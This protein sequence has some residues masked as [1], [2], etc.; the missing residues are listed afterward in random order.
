[1]SGGDAAIMDHEHGDW[2]L[3][4]FDYTGLWKP[5]L[6]DENDEYR[7]ASQFELELVGGEEVEIEDA[8]DNGLQ[9]LYESRKRTAHDPVPAAART[10]HRN[11][12][13]ISTHGHKLS[14]TIHSLTDS[15]MT[16][17]RKSRSS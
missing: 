11:R 6:K 12:H 8:G 3:H 4:L 5:R 1:M 14:K 13:G 7:D 17:G 16:A 2:S 15:V 9:S 10:A